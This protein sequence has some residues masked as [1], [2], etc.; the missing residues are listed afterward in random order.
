LKANIGKKVSGIV[1]VG[2]LGAMGVAGA[3]PAYAEDI[4]DMSSPAAQPLIRA[5]GMDSIPQK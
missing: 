2:L 4:Y 1:L 5:T 3:T